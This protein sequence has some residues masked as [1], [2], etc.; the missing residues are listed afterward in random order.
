MTDT[1][2][3]DEVFKHIDA[4]IDRLAQA[5]SDLTSQYGK[6]A[7]D[8]AVEITRMNGVVAE[9]TGLSCL[10]LVFFLVSI[11]PRVSGWAQ[12]NDYG[13][14]E[15]LST[16]GLYIVVTILTLCSLSNLLDFWNIIAIFN[17]KIALA[18]Q[19]LELASRHK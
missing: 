17:P 10:G 16:V 6:D 15:W 5:G 11:A 9:L 7:L 14:L 2:Q 18:H 8:M 19:I 1:T 12:K 3:T 13:G 4:Y